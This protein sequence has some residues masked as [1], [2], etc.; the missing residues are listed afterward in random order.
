MTDNEINIAIAKACGWKHKP[1]PPG[2]WSND[3]NGMYPSGLHPDTNLN[4]NF[5]IPSYL[6]D[7]NAMHGAEKVLLDVAY[8][9]P[10]YLELLPPE[11]LKIRATARQRDEAFLKTLGKWKD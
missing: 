4:Q 1:T 11:P 7:L 2:Y 3:D 5:N 9:W 8:A 6:S 10:Q